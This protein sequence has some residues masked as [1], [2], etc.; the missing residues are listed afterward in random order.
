MKINLEKGWQISQDVHDLGERCGLYRKDFNY[1]STSAQFSEWEN[2]PYFAH[3]QILLAK[4]PYFGRELRYFNNAPWWY[5]NTFKI[6]CLKHDNYAIRFVAVDYFCKVWLN[7][8]FV[9]QHEGYGTPFEFE[10][11]EHIKEGEN[12]LVVK[13]WSPWDKEVLPD[14]ED[15]RVFHVVRNMMKGTYE[16]DDTLIPRDVNP[17]GIYGGVYVEGINKAGFST[18]T[19]IVKA[20]RD[21][22]VELRTSITA[23]ISDDFLLKVKLF[24][25]DNGMLIGEYG[26]ELSIKEGFNEHEFNFTVSNIK[27]WEIFDNGEP[28][29]YD[30][31]LELLW[32]GGTISQ[33][34]ITIGFRDI[35]LN[36][37]DREVC[38][39]L[40]GKRLFLRGT[41]YMP[42]VYLSEMSYDRYKRDMDLVKQLG[43]NAIRIHVHTAKKE[44]YEICD[45]MGILIM[46]DSDFNWTH[47]STDD[48]EIRANNVFRDMIRH[49]MSHPSIFCWVC[50]NEPDFVK[51]RHHVDG[52]PGPALWKTVCEED[53][54]RP[55]IKA[56]YL[57]DDQFSGDSHNYLGSLEDETSLYTEIDS[58]PEKLNTEF[59]VDAPPCKENLRKQ[60]EIWNRIGRIEPDIESIQYYQYRLV[61]Y[62]IE[63]YRISRFKPCSGY[64]QFMLIDLCPQSYYGVFDWW[65]VPK[66]CIN[67]LYESNMPIGIFIKEQKDSNLRGNVFSIYVVNDY[68][69]DYENVFFEV[70]LTDNEGRKIIQKSGEISINADSLQIVCDFELAENVLN[71]VIKASLRLTDSTGKL[72][73][74]NSYDDLCNHPSRPDGHPRRMSHELGVRLFNA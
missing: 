56:S 50:M 19:R 23:A 72:I 68:F 33:K 47:S 60:D 39:F 31:R 57:P 53:P 63:S 26:K 30:A 38:F 37:N 3:L 44:L 58:R 70:N 21:G 22:K 20:G 5:R 34:E 10:V 64:F 62:Y 32:K 45:K 43:F 14:M 16:H 1:R 15:N 42:E 29:L 18:E 52:A 48:F 61:K 54:F 27:P 28:N 59:G 25:K 8:S 46:Q 17:V 69:M 66:Q 36:R 11:K 71:G 41:C 6:D 40:N 49:L 51:N 9:G 65:G 35:E 73:A 2:I 55:A 24:N 67:A 4:N 74:K 13:V 12:Y 7:G